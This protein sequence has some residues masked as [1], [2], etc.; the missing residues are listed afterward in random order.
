MKNIKL[1]FLTLAVFFAIYGTGYAQKDLTFV[2]IAHD[3]TTPSACLS[4]RMQELCDQGEEFGFPYIFYLA[5]EDQP[6]IVTLNLPGDNRG[7]FQKLIIEELNDKTYHPV[8]IGFDTDSI[9]DI[10]CQ[11]DFLDETGKLKYE[12]VTW[13][14]YIGEK[15]WD[16]GSHERFIAK[17]YWVMGFDR[18]KEQ[19]F[20][21]RIWSHNEVIKKLPKHADRDEPLPL[22]FGLRNLAKI[23]NDSITIYKYSCE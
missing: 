4:K 1:L 11:N 18:L 21:W 3:L 7:D 23:N 10:F 17:L 6:K 8:N 9:I 5:N 14:F 13:D 12:T 2:Y 20:S 16:E 15:F 22:Y 19:E